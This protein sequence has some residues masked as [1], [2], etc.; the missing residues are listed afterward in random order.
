L[1][2]KPKKERERKLFI[3]W[4]YREGERKREFTGR[5]S[6]FTSERERERERERLLLVSF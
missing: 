6:S 5:M 4:T 3:A 1:I 2:S